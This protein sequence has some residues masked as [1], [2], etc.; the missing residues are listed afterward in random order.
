MTNIY[1]EA[2]DAKVQTRN[3]VVGVAAVEVNPLEFRFVKGI[4]LRT[5]GTTDPTPNV[6]PIWLGHVN[7]TADSA[8]ET[9]GFPL[10]PGAS[11]FIPVE[12]LTGMYAIST[13]ASQVLTWMGV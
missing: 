11:I 4:L 13:S 7:V 12:L 10:V 9:G 6:A 5:P 3:V 8:V 2:V 1:R